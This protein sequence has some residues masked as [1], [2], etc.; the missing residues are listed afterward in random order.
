MGKWK[1]IENPDGKKI[2][3]SYSVSNSVTDEKMLV[4]I[5][6]SQPFSRLSLG[7]NT[8]DGSSNEVLGRLAQ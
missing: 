6:T 3:I 4:G 1:D 2:G 8:N 5:G 7:S